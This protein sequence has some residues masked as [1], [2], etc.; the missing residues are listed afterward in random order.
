VSKRPVP[1]VEDVDGDVIE[2]SADHYGLV[3]LRIPHTIVDLDEA[4]QEAFAQLYVAK[5]HEAR[6]MAEDMRRAEA[7]GAVSG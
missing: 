6:A 5:C 7:H 4:K 3:R 1:F 2:V